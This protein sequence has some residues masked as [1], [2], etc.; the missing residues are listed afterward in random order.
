MFTAQLIC[1]GQC[2]QSDIIRVFG[3]S[4]SSVKRSVKKYESGGIQAFFAPRAVRTGGT[5][6]NKQAKAKAQELLNLGQSRREVA[7]QLGI[8]YDTLRKAIN[9]GRLSEPDPQAK[10]RP[11]SKTA[12]LG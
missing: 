4:S 10:T 12:L 11:G 6:L 5:V 7:K 1:Q 3:V 2:K 8:K 9:Q